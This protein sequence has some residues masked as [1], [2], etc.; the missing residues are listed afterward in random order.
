M[1]PENQSAKV[2]NYAIAGVCIVF[3]ILM[4]GVFVKVFALQFGE[5]PARIYSS[6]E[7]ESANVFIGA[8]EDLKNVKCVA[9]DKEFFV[10]PEI[11]IGDLSKN[12]EDVCRFELAEGVGKP[13][14][15]EVWYN[16]KV[17]REVCEWQHYPRYD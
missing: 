4:L 11:V 8:N 16:G 14:R 1:E 17:E 12:D 3:T 6:C 7:N 2:R 15:F 13:L 10:N 9:L 5:S